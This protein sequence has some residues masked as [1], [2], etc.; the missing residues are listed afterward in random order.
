MAARNIKCVRH[1]ISI[2]TYRGQDSTW[3]LDQTDDNKNIDWCG[4]SRH[5]EAQ[6][7]RKMHRRT[8]WMEMINSYVWPT[9][10]KMQYVF[11]LWERQT[12]D[13]NWKQQKAIDS[14]LWN[15][16]SHGVATVQ[17]ETVI[18]LSH[19]FFASFYVVSWHACSASLVAPCC[20]DERNFSTCESSETLWTWLTCTH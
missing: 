8:E 3:T 20:C 4:T 19:V 9:L 7:Y 11:S 12:F 15:V 1:I 6:P 16:G 13:G 18:F 10:H 5:K 17:T 2:H 14:C